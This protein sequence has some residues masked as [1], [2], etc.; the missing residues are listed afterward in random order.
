[1]RMCMYANIFSKNIKMHLHT[2]PS[3]VTDGKDVDTATYH[4]S[5]PYFVNDKVYFRTVFHPKL[6]C[7]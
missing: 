6:D 2:F 4:L 7:F 3:V 5:S 1:M